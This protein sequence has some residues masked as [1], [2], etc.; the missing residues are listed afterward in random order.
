MAIAAIAANLGYFYS[1]LAQYA[2]SYKCPFRTS[3]GLTVLS[4]EY[5]YNS[6]SMLPYVF[7]YYLV[8]VRSLTAMAAS[9]SQGSSIESYVDIASTASSGSFSWPKSA[10]A[11]VLRSS[12]TCLFIAVLSWLGHHV[13]VNSGACL[14][15][16][17]SR[18]SH[19]H[20]EGFQKDF[21]YACSAVA[22]AYV[23][24]VQV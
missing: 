22:S 21:T 23:S 7:G 24:G 9:T 10:P 15:K 2:N 6:A 11:N 5:A 14:L 8:S 1:L 16:K 20:T 17:H 4:L 19:R 3:P 13:G 12:S 18:Q